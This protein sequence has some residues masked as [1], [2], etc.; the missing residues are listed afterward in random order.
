MLRTAFRNDIA[1]ITSIGNKPQIDDFTEFGLARAEIFG[2]KKLASFIGVA[3]DDIAVI[4]DHLG[5]IIAITID[6]KRIGKRERG[7]NA[8]LSTTFKG[9]DTD[10]SRIRGGPK[11][12]LPRN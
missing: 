6:Q 12:S 11:G 9:L 2:V 7:L 1:A 8:E 3:K 4:P 5:K 10:R